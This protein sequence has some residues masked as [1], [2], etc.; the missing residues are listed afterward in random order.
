MAERGMTRQSLQEILGAALTGSEEYILTEVDSMIGML[1]DKI[2]DNQEVR[3]AAPA[4]NAGARVDRGRRALSQV[5]RLQPAG[6][7][8]P[9][10]GFALTQIF[11]ALFIAGGEKDA[12]GYHEARQ[13]GKCTIW[14]KCVQHVPGRGQHLDK[15]KSS[16]KKLSTVLVGFQEWV[17]VR[18]RM[19]ALRQQSRLEIS[20]IDQ[21]CRGVAARARPCKHL[22]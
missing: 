7:S 11:R 16:F 2:V 12:Q 14:S 22:N 3:A 8:T 13:K 17:A 20:L 21:H 18:D 10:N 9:T 15:G 4:A 19:Q 1:H 6:L 5:G